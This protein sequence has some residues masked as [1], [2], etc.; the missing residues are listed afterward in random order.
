LIVELAPRHAEIQAQLKAA[1]ARAEFRFHSRF[2]FYGTPKPEEL[3]MLSEEAD[4]LT[5]E[6][7]RLTAQFHASEK[8][9][10]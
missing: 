4:R 8:R 2:R 6:A 3:A 10:K 9:K 1:S 5:E 7:D